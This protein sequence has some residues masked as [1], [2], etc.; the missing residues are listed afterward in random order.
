MMFATVV[1]LRAPLCPLL[2]K[3][4]PHGVIIVSVAER[5]A[6][7][8]HTSMFLRMLFRAATLRRA[9][10]I[11]ALVAM[12]VAAGVSTAMLTLYVDVQAKLRKEFRN[13]GAN[14][15]VVA[16]DGQSLP[17]EALSTVQSVL[18]SKSQAVPFSYSIARL[19]DGRPVVV[20][21]TDLQQVR[22]TR[23]LVVSYPVAR[24]DRRSAR[25]VACRR[26]LVSPNQ[27]AFRSRF[28]RTH[29]SP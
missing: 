1:F 26:R 17:P 12:I 9:C 10:A 4:F 20:V 21:G 27:A 2:L 22:R 11:T 24:R 6:A 25:R 14:V 8:S 18:G 29:H 7:A 13:Y 3:T 5:R 23:P 28:P 16:K 19:P 15:V